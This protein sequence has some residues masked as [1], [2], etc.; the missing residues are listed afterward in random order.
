MYQKCNFFSVSFDPFREKLL[1]KKKRKNMN[2]YGAGESIRPL[3]VGRT[4]KTKNCFASFFRL[5]FTPMFYYLYIMQCTVEPLRQY[6]SG[7][8]IVLHFYSGISSAPFQPIRGLRLTW[9]MVEQSSGELLVS[10]DSS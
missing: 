3:V 2:H 8:S 5:Q 7:N 4:I 10:Y 9:F 6:T 1:R